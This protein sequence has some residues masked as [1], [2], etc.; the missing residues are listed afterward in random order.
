MISKICVSDWATTMNFWDLKCDLPVT[1]L[2]NRP[3]RHYAIRTK[4]REREREVMQNMPGF[5]IFRNV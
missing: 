3:K 1:K 5:H 4:E 2:S